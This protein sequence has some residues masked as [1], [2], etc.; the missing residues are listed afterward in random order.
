MR[1]Q[2][3]ITRFT[4]PTT[5]PV[6]EAEAQYVGVHIPT[7]RDLFLRQP[8]ELAYYTLKVVRQYDYG[9]R[10]NH[11]LTAWRFVIRYLDPAKALADDA[12]G[13]LRGRQALAKRDQPHSIGGVRRF[14]VKEEVVLDRRSGQTAAAKYVFEYERYPEMAHDQAAR[15][16]RSIADEVIARAGTAIG[17]RLVLVNWVESEIE[18]HWQ[19]SGQYETGAWVPYPTCVALIEFLFDSEFWG[20]QFFAQ[21]GLNLLMLDARLDNSAGYLVSERCELDKR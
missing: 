14:D 5:H 9:G 1:M 8:E 12:V 6:A 15:I 19:P 10:W 7:A 2:K 3:L 4:P 21:D 13:D 17:L 20:E 16:V 18:V 11:R